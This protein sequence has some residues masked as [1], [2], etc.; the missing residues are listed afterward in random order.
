[1]TNDPARRG[2]SVN[3]WNSTLPDR[4]GYMKRTPFTVKLAAPVT[5]TSPASVP[6]SRR[7]SHSA[8]EFSPAVRLLVRARA[9]SGDP[10]EARCEAC[11]A[12][13]GRSAGEVQHRLARGIGGSKN[14]VIRCAAN[15]VL[16]C[17]SALLR[18]GC[19]GECEKRNRA[20]LIKGFRL[21]H[22]AD[23]RAV[24]VTLPPGRLVLLAENGIG[25][26]G[27]GYLAIDEGIAA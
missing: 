3:A 2:P 21:E 15:A 10:D 24:P 9:G 8:G 22:P 17:G 19:H 26:D 11:G 7:S 27:T 23:P 25:P 4:S 20:L 1:M 12:W 5:C 14:P 18:T 6:P 13:L 16:L